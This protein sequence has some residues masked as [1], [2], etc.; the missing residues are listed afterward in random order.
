[1]LAP[2]SKSKKKH[3]SNSLVESAD[4][5]PLEEEGRP[6]GSKN[7]LPTA[8]AAVASSGKLPTAVAAAASAWQKTT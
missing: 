2:V 3:K 8:A 6:P 1:M 7:K 5:Q 4:K